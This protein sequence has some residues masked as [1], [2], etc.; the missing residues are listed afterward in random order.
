[1]PNDRPLA[2]AFAL[3]FAIACSDDGAAGSGGGEQGGGPTTGSS[4]SGTTGATSTT[5]NGSGATTNGSTTAG[6]QCDGGPLAE[7]IPGCA[8]APLPSSGDI[9]Q[10]CVDRINQLRWECQCLPPLARWTDAEACT[11]QQSADDQAADT[12]HGNFPACGENAQNTCPNWGSDA[13][14]IGGCLQMMWDEGPGPFEQHGHY[15]NMSSTGYSKVACGFSSSN[16]GVWSNQN[17]SP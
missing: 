15:I 17:F 6:S 11:D 9:H 1:M 8:P 16:A 14:V 3:A 4:P 7:P 12:P 5:G 13:E 10:D 2:L